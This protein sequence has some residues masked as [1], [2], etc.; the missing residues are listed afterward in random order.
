MLTK[1]FTLFLCLIGPLVAQSNQASITGVIT[2]S[3][4]AI[5]PGAKITATN[6]DTDAVYPAISNDAGFYSISN[7]AIGGYKLTVVRDGFRSYQRQRFTISTGQVIGLDVQLELGAVSETVSVTGEAQLLETRTSD[8]SQLIDSKS[9]EDLP[10]G[11][12]RTLNAINLTGAAVFVSYGNSPGNANPNFSL[13]GGR[14]QS[15]MFWIDGGSG[16]N[17]RLGVGQINLDP[18]VETVEE[19]KVLTNSNSAE[20]GGSAGGII[21]AT[22]K[23]GTNKFHGALYEYLRNDKMDA[24][25]FFAAIQN[26]KKAIPELR[27]NVFG[28]TIGGPIIKDKTFFF[29]AYEGQRLRT[30]G[31]DTSPYQLPHSD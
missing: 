31:V 22:T 15:Q 2:D 25:G 4:R 29:F 12:R 20:Y 21:V 24:P 9:I 23:S 19:I 26:G 11:N 6:L 28:G 18:P 16:Q 1:W 30:G 13:A 8:V 7:I 5:V 14:S 3:Q 17:M 10:L 27:Y